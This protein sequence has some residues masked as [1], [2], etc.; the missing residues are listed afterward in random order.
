MSSRCKNRDH[1]K[2]KCW[3]WSGTNDCKTIWFNPDYGDIRRKDCDDDRRRRDDRDD[4]R[5]RKNDH[6]DN[7]KRL[8]NSIKW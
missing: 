4:D 3:R 2:K 7:N 5:H 6:D 8:W 1:R